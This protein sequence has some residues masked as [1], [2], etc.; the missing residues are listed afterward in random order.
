MPQNEI[1]GFFF[2]ISFHMGI[3]EMERKII[4]P[5]NARVD[6]LKMLSCT[7]FK[8]KNLIAVIYHTSG[9]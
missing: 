5:E 1:V 7:V 8:T 2:L 4:L 3:E 6:L 9:Y